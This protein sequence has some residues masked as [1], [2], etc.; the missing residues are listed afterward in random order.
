MTTLARELATIKQD[1][2]GYCTAEGLKAKHPKFV[3]WDNLEPAEIKELADGMNFATK[4]YAEN[5]TLRKFGLSSR[6]TLKKDR[7]KLRGA[8]KPK[9][10]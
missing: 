5:L 8:K 7:R 1:L 3:L 4:A 2:D 10:S 9:P 6:E